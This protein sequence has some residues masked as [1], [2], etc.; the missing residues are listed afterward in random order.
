MLN[1]CGL[2]APPTCVTDSERCENDDYGYSISYLCGT[3]GTWKAIKS[4]E[5]CNGNNC[6]GGVSDIGCD[7]EGKT[8]CIDTPSNS[9]QFTCMNHFW[10]PEICHSQCNDDHCDLIGLCT[11]ESQESCTYI[12]SLDIAVYTHCNDEHKLESLYCPFKACDGNVCQ[13]ENEKDNVTVCG[14]AGIDCT[15]TIES[16]VSGECTEGR[17]VVFMCADGK[18]PYTT[19]EASICEPNDMDNCG[20]HGVPCQTL[21]VAK[22]TTVECSPEGVCK[23]TDCESGYHVYEGACEKDDN[24]NC[25]EHGIACT[26]DLV[27]GSETVSCDSGECIAVTCDSDHVLNG[28]VCMDKSCNDGDIKCE[29]TGTTGKLYQCSGNSWVEQDT[30]ASNYSCKSTTECG[31]CINNETS[32]S[33]NDKVGQITTCSGGMKSTNACP[34]SYSCKSTTS[35]GT[36]QNGQKRCS[37][38]NYQTCSTGT[39]STTQTCTAPYGGTATCDNTTG[40]G[41]TC[42]SGSEYNGTCCIDSLIITSPNYTNNDITCISGYL[43]ASNDS[44]ESIVM[45]NLVYV[46]ERLILSSSNLTSI[47]FESLDTT[48]GIEINGTNLETINFPQLQNVFNEFYIVGNTQ[49]KY[50]RVPSLKTITLAHASSP[51]SSYPF[52][53]ETNHLLEEITAPNL[54]D[55][56]GDS[57]CYSST[58][59]FGIFYN[60]QLS[61]EQLCNISALRKLT[62]NLVIT[63]NASDECKFD[64]PSG[65]TTFGNVC[66]GLSL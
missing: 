34:D 16:W 51:S 8:K 40:C 5:S 18:H 31:E 65:S 59:L 53:I 47:S 63:T 28:S 15:T 10:I 4:C 45:N 19:N 39:W 56:H 1:G 43:S 14:E 26:K 2:S 25:H 41:F 21:S 60:T 49:L 54:T 35:C 30:C 38:N 58:C 9:I 61:C 57:S 66:S 20:E 55:I 48:Y 52:K 6:V 44:I 23:A 36:C 11:S 62:S 29:D 37:D 32:C 46:G 17:C 24:T 33:D 13:K 22:S 64:E 27:T 3:D 50:I 12:H 42:T 7:T